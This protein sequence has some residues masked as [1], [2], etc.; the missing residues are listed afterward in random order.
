MGDVWVKMRKYFI[1]HTLSKLE[2][3]PYLTKHTVDHKGHIS[4]A[5]SWFKC[6]SKCLL[7]SRKVI[8]WTSY[9]IFANAVSVLPLGNDDGLCSCWSLL[10]LGRWFR[11]C[12]RASGVAGFSVGWLSA[13]DTVYSSQTPPPIKNFRY[14]SRASFPLVCILIGSPCLPENL[15]CLVFL[16]TLWPVYFKRKLLNHLEFYNVTKRRS[17]LAQTS[18]RAWVG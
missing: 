13:T 1:L 5:K 4:I 6:L 16:L 8:S 9:N 12:T 18:S 15:I 2:R 7:S 11:S 3:K 17:Y 10:F 14:N